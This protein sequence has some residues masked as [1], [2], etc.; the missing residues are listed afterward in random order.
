MPRAQAA[1]NLI[2]AAEGRVMT[3]QPAG[4]WEH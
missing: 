3:G 2:E 4:V 1:L